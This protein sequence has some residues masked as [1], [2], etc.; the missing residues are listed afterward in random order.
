MRGSVF[1]ILGSGVLVVCAP[2]CTQCPDTRELPEG[3]Y[4]TD[5]SIAS[6]PASAS[7]GVGVVS[8]DALVVEYGTSVPMPSTWRV[9]M[10]IE[11][12]F[13]LEEREDGHDFGCFPVGEDTGLTALS[14]TSGEGD[15]AV[16]ETYWSSF[17]HI[18]ATDLPM[19]TLWM[20]PP[21]D[22]AGGDAGE[23]LSFSAPLEP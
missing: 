10:Q 23:T 17:H 9:V 11:R 18:T 21:E 4:V 5:G 14:R 3:T 7:D 19:F 22:P 1:G 13:R 16:Q 8:G 6:I 20:N 2:G 12:V 15:Q